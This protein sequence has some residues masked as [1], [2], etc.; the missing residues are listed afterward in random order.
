MKIIEGIKSEMIS[1]SFGDYNRQNCMMIS[2]QLKA[3]VK[4]VFTALAELFPR[5]QLFILKHKKST[6][7]LRIDESTK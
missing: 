5:I 7:L 6:P 3:M 4:T 2:L 1:Q